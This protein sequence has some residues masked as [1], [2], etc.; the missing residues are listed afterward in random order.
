MKRTDTRKLSE[1]KLSVTLRIDELRTA[2]AA[3]ERCAAEI[4]REERAAQ[5]EKCEDHV[6][7][8]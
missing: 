1:R 2:L 6:A 4:D 8:E 3:A 5:G 7:A